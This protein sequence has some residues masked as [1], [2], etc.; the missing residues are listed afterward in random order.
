MQSE[1]WLYAREES[2]LSA[3]ASMFVEVTTLQ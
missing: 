1:N 2:W 3:K